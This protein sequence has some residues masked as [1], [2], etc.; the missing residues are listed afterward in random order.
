VAFPIICS[1][2]RTLYDPIPLAPGTV[3]PKV[4]P[5]QTIRWRLIPAAQLLQGIELI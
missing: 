4:C 3:M 1:D 5:I 2:Q